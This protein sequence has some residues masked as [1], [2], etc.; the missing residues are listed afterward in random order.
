M[1]GKLRLELHQISF[2]NVVEAAVDSAKPSAETKGIRLKTI[3]GVSQD[4]INA[5]G[6]RLQQ[7]VWN[8]LTNAIKFTPK[9]GQVHVVLQRVNSHLELSVGDTASNSWNCTAQLRRRVRVK[10]RVPRSP[11]S[12]PS[13][14]YS[15]KTRARRASIRPETQSG[16]MLSLPSLEGVHVFSVDDEPD[17]RELLL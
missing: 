9:G 16:E 14:L 15:C 2:A 5:D 11:S 6:A 4:I 7:V 8:L 12:C 13:L 3:L 10:A 17:A 1:T